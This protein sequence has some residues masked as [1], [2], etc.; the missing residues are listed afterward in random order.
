MENGPD[1]HCPGCGAPQR[2]FDR[3]P[4][5]FCGACLA[6]AADGDGRRLVFGNTSISGGFAWAYA[7]DPENRDD[8]AGIVI[9]R[10]RERRVT[11]EEARFG[12][13]VAQPMGSG[14]LP[15]LPGERVVHLA[16]RGQPQAGASRLRRRQDRDRRQEGSR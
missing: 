3:Y 11:V 9:C 2:R 14:S 5:Y 15:L 16:D 1:H 7:D 10:I 8:T 13:I 6:E 12:G 4:W